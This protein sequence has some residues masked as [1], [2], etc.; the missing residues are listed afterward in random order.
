MENLRLIK[1]CES[2]ELSVKNSCKDK[3][4]VSFSGGIDSTLI[5]FLARKYCAVELI[6]VG[7]PD[8]HDLRAATSAAKKI[9]MELKIL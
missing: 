9:N 5:A 6:A 7:V 3:V 2:I 1:L 4:S 8:A